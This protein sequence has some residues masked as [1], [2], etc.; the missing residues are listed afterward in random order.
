ML[1]GKGTTSAFLHPRTSLGSLSP[2]LSPT[3]RPRGNGRSEPFFRSRG[4]PS[5]SP[6]AFHRSNTSTRYPTYPADA[7]ADAND[8]VQFLSLS[9]SVLLDQFDQF[10]HRHG[11]ESYY[12]PDARTGTGSDIDT[13]S[14]LEDH[15]HDHDRDVIM[16][17]MYASDEMGGDLTVDPQHALHDTHGQ[18]NNNDNSNQDKGSDPVPDPSSPT[19]SEKTR[20]DKMAFVVTPLSTSI[21]VGD[22]VGAGKG[23]GSSKGSRK[24]LKGRTEVAARP[25]PTP[26]KTT[27]SKSFFTTSKISNTMARNNNHGTTTPLAGKGNKNGGGTGSRMNFKDAPVIMSRLLSFRRGNNDN[28]NSNG[29]SSNTKS[30]TGTGLGKSSS[31]GVKAVSTPGLMNLRDTTKQPPVQGKA[32]SA[33]KSKSPFVRATQAMKQGLSF[34]AFRRPSIYGEDDLLNKKGSE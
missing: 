24:G 14:C 9:N 2:S 33:M 21:R 22:K 1:R 30:S 8:D 31:S 7:D 17:D 25:L 28:S 29:S 26:G 23:S 10:D 3:A 5:L 18:N 27:K 4:S 34:S 20:R 12:N 6:P 16:G 11:D 15:D 19:L 13:I 32:H